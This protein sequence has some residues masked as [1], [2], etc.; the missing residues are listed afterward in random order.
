MKTLWRRSWLIISVITLAY[1]FALSLDVSPYV[2]GPEEWRWARRPI[3][4]WDKVWPLALVLVLIAVGVWWIDRRAQQADRAHR[5]IALGVAW[6]VVAVPIVQMLALRA[7]RA[8]PFEALFDRAVDVAANSYFT[9]GLRIAN[10]DEALRTY[11]QLMPTLDI[12]AQVHPPGLPLIYWAAGRVLDAAPSLARQVSLW[13]RQLECNDINLMLLSDAQLASGW[14]GMLIPLLANMLTVLGIFKLAKDRFGDR[15]GLYAAALWVIVPSA[16]LFPGSWSLV[17]PC[18]ACLTWLAVDAGLRRRKVIWFL[19]AG[20]LLS[21][22]TFLELGTAALGVFLILYILAR[23]V[24]ERRNPLRD[25]HFLLPALLVALIGVYSIWGVY[26]LGYGVSL[27]QIVDAM[28]PIHT[29]YT[30]DRLT[31]LINHPYEFAVF[32]GLPI[33]CLLIVVSIRAIKEARARQGDALSVSFLISLIA[34]TLVDPARDETARTWMLFMPFAVIAV[35]QLFAAQAPHP[36]RF[37]W[38]WSLMTVQVVTMLAVLNVVQVGL[39]GLPPRTKVEALPPTAHAKQANFGGMAQ[40]IGYETQIQNDRLIV[41][42]YWRRNGQIDQP[43]VV[44][45]HVLN[46]QRQMIGQQ[47]DRPQAG[48]PLMTCWQPSEIYADQHVI[49]LASDPPPGPYTLEMGLY[50]AVTSQRVPVTTLDGSQTDH[51]EIGPIEVK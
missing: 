50:N 45:N 40:L 16:V 2:R 9:A 51:V 17:Y 12:P 24:T 42:W 5:R 43:Y 20:V 1:V 23:Y 31:W 37:S 3:A 38:L 19:L 33:F 34:L 22:G 47:D 48:Q 15:S 4:Q 39:Y 35:S 10:V 26:Q 29:G 18:L 32:L 7:D 11:P 46:E 6:L 36:G 49:M 8:D 44:F 14:A 25:L 27:K 28:Y 41:D 21:I 30:F 13:F